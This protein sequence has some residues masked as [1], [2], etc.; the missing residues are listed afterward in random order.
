[1]PFNDRDQPESGRDVSLFG[2]VDPLLGKIVGGRWEIL[3]FHGEG[4]MSVVYKAQDLEANEIVVLKIL[5][6]H[7]SSNAKSLKRFEQRAKAITELIHNRIARVLDINLSADGQV[8]LVVEPLRG[9]SLEDLLAK[10]GHLTVDHA[11]EIFSQSCDALDYAHNHDVLHRDIKPSNIML[12]ETDSITDDVALVDFGIGR[13]LSEENDDIKSSGYITRTR[14]VFGS[15]MYMSPEQCMGKRL[16]AR[17]DIYSLGCVMYETLTGKPPFVGKNVLETAYKH[18]NEAPK[19]MLAETS[20][21]RSLARLEAVI[22]KCLAKD[23]NERYQLVSQL[24]ADLQIL[25]KASD[26]SWLNNA[27][28]LKKIAKVKKKEKKNFKIS[29]ELGVFT[30]AAMLLIAVVGVWCT[31]FLVPEAQTYP[32]FNNDLLFVIQE[33]KTPMEVPDFAAQ[34]EAYRT[35]VES[36]GSTKGTDS[37]EYVDALLKLE[38][39][40]RDA[41]RWAEA[42]QRLNELKDISAKKENIVPMGQLYKDLAYCSFLQDKLD[43]AEKYSIQCVDVFEK[44]GQS[45]ETDVMMMPLNI[46]GDIYSRRKDLNKAFS[47]YDKQYQLADAHKL[48]DIRQYIFATIKLGDIYRRQN[49]IKDADRM[50]KLGLDAAQSYPSQERIFMAKAKYG[51]GLVLEK[52][53][54]Y[55]EAEAI[56]REALPLVK[57]LTGEK[58]AFVGAVKKQ[59]SECLWKT[60]WV[61]AMTARFSNEK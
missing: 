38:G 2:N 20:S 16:D 29:F 54:R 60:N 19:P 51:Y 21:S 18:M 11:V 58:S 31:M 46:L 36:V 27:Y 15:P 13:L 41:G 52:S 53:D 25:L 4:S 6:Q 40:Y 1:M 33:K 5:H 34:E 50:Y 7:L 14:E 42:E 24:R 59:I 49:K 43:N 37:K 48:V 12:L 10:T 23:P 17:S 30:G 57:S 44:N 61:A 9:E 45:N 22:F 26:T 3:E 47:T 28:A 8:I 35:D 32:P 39:L 55:K 56:F